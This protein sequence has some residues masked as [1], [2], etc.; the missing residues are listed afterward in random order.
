MR[1][2][3]QLPMLVEWNSRLSQ[4]TVGLVI[5]RSMSMPMFQMGVRGMS[6]LTSLMSLMPLRQMLRQAM[7][8]F[9]TVMRVLGF[10]V[11]LLTF[12]EVLS[13]FG[14]HFQILFD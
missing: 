3:Q 12:F 5:M 10:L 14:S 4:L 11:V 2:I 13:K 6:M 7:W 1:R 9:M 8:V